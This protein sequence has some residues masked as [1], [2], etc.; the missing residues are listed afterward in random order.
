MRTTV[1]MRSSPRRYFHRPA[2][3]KVP[4]AVI[5]SLLQCVGVTVSLCGCHCVTVWMLL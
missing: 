2:L 3:L 5:V 1:K 4:L